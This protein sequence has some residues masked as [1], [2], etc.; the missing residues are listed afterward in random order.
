MTSNFRANAEVKITPP[1]NLSV[2]DGAE[3]APLV[4][5]TLRKAQP[6][7]EHPVTGLLRV[8]P[9]QLATE[10]IPN[11]R[12]RAMRLFYEGAKRVFDLLLGS[13]LLIIAIPLILIAAA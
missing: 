4:R 1:P 7:S 2:T 6:F 13:V 12:S 3:F 5:A 10:L 8:E 11:P 9:A